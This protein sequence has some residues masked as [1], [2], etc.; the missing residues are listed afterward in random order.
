[1][2]V[3]V[4]NEMRTMANTYVNIYTLVGKQSSFELEEFRLFGA[5]KTEPAFH[6]STSAIGK[7]D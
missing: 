7:Q 1:M 2:K 3:V 5:V 4:I 6:A